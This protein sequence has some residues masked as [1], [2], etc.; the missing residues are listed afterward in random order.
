MPQAADDKDY[1]V[2]KAERK[3]DGLE[4]IDRNQV[5]EVFNATADFLLEFV[6]AQTAPEIDYRIADIV[7]V[8]S[9]CGIKAHDTR[10]EL[11]HLLI[12]FT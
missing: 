12:I 10:L 7:T 4:Q 11:S 1:H 9:G 2:K 6:Q 3:D 5:D 8:G